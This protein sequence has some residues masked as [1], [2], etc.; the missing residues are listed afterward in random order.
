M[1]LR[2]GR[3][4]GGRSGV[5][6][7]ED[8]VSDSARRSGRLDDQREA[9]VAAAE[10]AK[11]HGGK[12]HIVTAYDPKSVRADDLP[13]ELRYSQSIHPADALLKNLSEIGKAQGLEVEVQR[14]PAPRPKRS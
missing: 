1:G 14:P 2:A 3:C 9:V 8:D 11:L 4:P 12:F 5:G 6:R 13:P 7:E 10:V